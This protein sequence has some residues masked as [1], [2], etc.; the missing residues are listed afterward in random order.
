LAAAVEAAQQSLGLAP[1]GHPDHVA[2]LSNLA[3]ALIRRFE[4]ARN[5]ADLDAAIDAAKQA[6]D[7]ALVGYQDPAVCLAQLGIALRERF[8]LANDFADLSA[9]VDA[10]QESVDAAPPG[11]RDHGACLSILAGTLLRRFEVAGDLADLN[12]AVDAARQSVDAAP[13]GRPDPSDL[14]SLGIALMRQ[15]EQTG[16]AAGLDAAIGACRQAVSLIP[17]SHADRAKGLSN[18]GSALRMR[19]DLARD[20][21]DIDAAVD[22]GRRSVDAAAAGRAHPSDLT[23]LANSLLS[24][25]EWARDGADLDAAIDAV[26]QAADLTPPG[27]PDRAL[28]LSNLVNPLLLRFEQT[29]DPAD[30]DAA[31]DAGR[32]GLDAVP[33]RHPNIAVYLSN[34]GNALRIRFERTGDSADL[35]AAINAGRRAVDM[36]RP[37]HPELARF[38]SIFGIALLRR[39]ELAGAPADLDATISCWHR[40]SEMSAGAPETRLAAAM[41]WG[42]EAAAA[43]LAHEAAEGYRAAVRILPLLA[44]HGLNR[45]TREEHLAKWAGVAV[46]AAACAVIDGRPELAMEL[47]EQGRSVLWNQ[48]LNL[49]G[50]LSGLAERAPA[51]AERLDR[52]R[53]VLDS[54]L[55][56]PAILPEPPR[57]GI[58]AAGRALQDAAEVR[59]RMAREWDDVLSQVR[60]LPGFE[61]F[62]AGIPYADLAAA[63]DDGP[64]V[65]VNASRY[66]CHA[67]I[68][69]ADR[70]RIQVVSLP[71]LA[72][73]A[74]INRANEMLRVLADAS[75]SAELSFLDREKNRRDLLG[76]L[77]WLWDVIAEPV[78]SA[79]GYTGSPGTGDRWPRVWWCPTGPLTVLPIHAAGHY[80]SLPS[81]GTGDADC[82]LGRVV[83]SYTTTLTALIRARQLT[84]P[85]AVRQLTVGMAA[86]PGQQPLTAVPAELD[87]IAGHFPLGK[88]NHQLPG[89]K[90]T[91]DAVLTALASHSWVHMACHAGQHH[92]DPDRTG[93]AL[94]DGTLTVSDLTAQPT[95]RRDLAFLSACQ[96]ATGSVRHLDEAIHLAAAM[97]YLGYR[98]VIG[99]MWTISDSLAPQVANA[100]Y[101]E[102]TR[103]G[104]PDPTRA[105]EALHHAIR[106]L[107]QKDRKVDPLLWAPYVH[108]GC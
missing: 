73:D 18:L 49:R 27:L 54:P 70:E 104:T 21:T 37:G 85:V 44:W 2:A 47:L 107:H 4:L 76:V 79:L 89:P 82:V 10:G 86:T 96:T 1:P 11:H 94:W 3:M 78:L 102:L 29:G 64:V 90:A 100:V 45:A 39:F 26:Q 6:A 36:T 91:R 9:A 87:V 59:R 67:L 5:A 17:P 80:P 14:S 101:T 15:F 43:G 62:L 77:S 40:A 69:G 52:I 42:N 65:I 12:A 72:L 108:L 74:A 35:E 57:G 20:A 46:D 7:A 22:A 63:G 30:L 53:K 71:D 68:T 106:I 24:R 25:F 13:A 28:H 31:I 81:G 50:D 32:Q 88:D 66:G 95:Q 33:A 8:E 99:T 75:R 48:A 58:T 34:L 19:F 41:S 60:A 55:S 84:A 61:H 83:S 38:L 98:H 56:S 97:Q 103:D 105:A 93:F 51:L 23:N 92:A 16:D